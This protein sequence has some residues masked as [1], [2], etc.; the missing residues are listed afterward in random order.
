MSASTK[1]M[2]VIALI[3]ILVAATVFGLMLHQVIAQ[4][5]RLYEQISMLE[6]QNAQEESYYRLL[7]TAEDSAGDRRLLQQYFLERESDSIDFLNYI[8][9]LAPS[10]GVIIAGEKTTLDVVK[11]KDGTT[12]WVTASFAFSGTRHNVQNFIQILE[13]LPYVS[14]STQVAMQ[15]RAANNWEANVTIQVRVLA[16]ED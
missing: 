3:L 14:R 2:V 8:E 13:T 4:S 9:T 15:V 5:E 16:Y 6:I 12:S 10:A 1:R 11:E 7:R